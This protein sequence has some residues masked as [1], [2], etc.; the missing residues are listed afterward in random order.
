MVNLVASTSIS[1][2]GRFV[3]IDRWSPVSRIIFVF[4][5]ISLCCVARGCVLTSGTWSLGNDLVSEAVFVL[6]VLRCC[7][8]VCLTSSGEDGIR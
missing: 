7:V 2:S 3:L 1:W 6:I 4:M 8:V 5:D